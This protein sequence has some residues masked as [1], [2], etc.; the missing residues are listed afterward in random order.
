CHAEQIKSWRDELFADWGY[1]DVVVNNAGVASH[2]G[3][4]EGSLE[5]W[6]WVIDINLKGVARGCKFFSEAFKQQGH[7]HVVNIASM[8]GLIHSPEMA[9]Y[10]AVKA[11]VVAISETMRFEL[12]PFG[13]HTTVVCPGFFQTNLAEST[14]S[15]DQHAKAHVNKML[16]TSDISADDI[17][18]MIFDGVENKSFYVLPHKAYRKS[19]LIKRYLP[20]LYNKQMHALG[21]KL[22]AA[23]KAKA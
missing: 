10:N 12:E 16:A 23:R 20:F 3:I 4:A 13:I 5:D 7:G 1:I 22:A 15:P 14:R 9:S 17:A 2:G 19:W 18:D 11:A 8:A 21:N 6:D